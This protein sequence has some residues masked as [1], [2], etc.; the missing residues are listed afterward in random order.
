MEKKKTEQK[1]SFEIGIILILVLTLFVFFQVKDFDFLS[2]WDDDS[3]I[4]RNPSI[5]EISWENIK[6][7]FSSIYVSNYQPVSILSYLVE[8]SIFKLSP[9]GY[10]VVNMLFHLV[11]V[12]LVY[13]FFR[14]MNFSNIIVYTCTLLFAV[15]PTRVESI[16]W[17]AERKDLMYAMFYLIS[18]IQYLKYKSEEKVKHYWFSLLF[19]ILSCLSKSMGVTLPLILVLID[20]YQ[21]RK[22]EWKPIL[23]KAPFFLVSLVIGVV[24]LYTQREKAMAIALDFDLYQRII[25]ILFAV[26][27]YFSLIIAPFGLAVIQY[28][29]IRPEDSVG[30]DLILFAVISILAVA[31]LLKSKANRW[32][33]IFGLLFFFFSIGIVIQIVPFGH[34]VIAERYTYLPYL[35]LFFVLGNLLE[36]YLSNNKAALYSILTIAVIYFSGITFQRLKVW[37]NS[38]T[39]F[40]DLVEKFPENDHAYWMRGNVLKDYKQYE[41]A[42]QDYNKAIQLNPNYDMA[43]FNRAVCK[44]ATKRSKEALADYDKTIELNPTYAPAY[45]NKANSLNELKM[46]DEALDNFR[47]AASFDSTFYPPF[48]GIGDIFLLRN[49]SDSAI[50]YYKKYMAFD[51]LNT[52]MLHNMGVAYYN[53]QDK[54]MYCKIWKKAGDMGAAQ[55][56]QL[57]AQFCISR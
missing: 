28:Y 38:I 52:N 1:K 3:Y 56:K 15:H 46:Y 22:V 35:G 23:N 36:N 17:I 33:N 20:A 31:L 43:Y 26:W 2:N 48:L 50:F 8:Y 21:S 29:P 25:L 32:E 7:I 11:N 18:M 44:A 39:L 34:A 13:S 4:I 41:P 16:A 47:K 10:H 6:K 37:Q 24:A 45:N 27:K 9:G 49:E 51:S 42:E 40:T 53:K 30:M 5:Y 12:Y 54:D 19:F 55:S 14:L 57:H